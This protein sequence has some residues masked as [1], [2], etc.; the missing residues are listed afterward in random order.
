MSYNIIIIPRFLFVFWLIGCRD[1]AGPCR[2]A[3][4]FV[5]AY[6]INHYEIFVIKTTA[7]PECVC[8]HEMRKMKVC[9]TM[10]LTM[11]IMSEHNMEVN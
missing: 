1:Q 8:L 2:A 7:K 4:I 9:N 10:A 11:R 3:V 5:Y 6:I